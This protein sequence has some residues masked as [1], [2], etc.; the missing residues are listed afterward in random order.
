MK[1]FFIFLTIIIFV[2]VVIYLAVGSRLDA[3]NT[4]RARESIV[5]KDTVS[6]GSGEYGYITEIYKRIGEDV[7]E[8]EPL[9][10]YA[11]I[12][13]T[14]QNQ[15]GL[16][17]RDLAITEVRLISVKEE[18][19]SQRVDSSMKTV[20]SPVAGILNSIFLP[21]GSYMTRDDK[22]MELQL[23]SFL[24][25]S[26][27]KLKPNQ[28]DV[29]KV[30]TP[31][32]ITLPNGKKVEGYISFIHPE[33]DYENQ[34]ITVDSIITE[35]AGKLYNGTPVSVEIKRDDQLYLVYQEF[36]QY[37]DNKFDGIFGSTDTP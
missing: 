28:F 5:V 33:Y 9:F 3:R 10:S 37:F 15:R 21:K 20:L 19:L 26:T 24:I 4:M 35:Q 18:L 17:N 6:V 23:N 14:S 7:D 22:V 27:I 29:L 31:V 25:R 16:F 36:K 8:G 13:N 34:E 1:R 11:K 12:E 32:I 2:F 30:D